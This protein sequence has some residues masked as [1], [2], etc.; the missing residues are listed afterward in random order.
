MRARSLVLRSVLA[1]AALAACTDVPIDDSRKDARLFPARGV[2][3][4]TVTYNGPRP[5][6]QGQHIVGNA[7]ILVFDRRNPP[8]PSG[9]AASA[10]NFVAVPGDV[11]FANEPRSIGAEIFCPPDPEPITASAPFAIAPL[12]GASYMIQAFYDRRGRFSPTFKFRNLPEAGD[13]GGGYIDLADF[14]K[15]GTNPAYQP[16]YLPVDVGIRQQADVP[17]GQ[18]PDFAIG[19]SGYVADNVPVTLGSIVP[20]TRPYFHPEGAEDL[21]PPQTSDANVTGDPLAVPVVAMTQDIHVFAPPASPTPQT[22]AAYES[23][24]KSIK[25]LWSV[26]QSEEATATDPAQPFGLQLPPLPP[27]GKGGLLVFSR[28]GS[29]PDN[30]AVPALWPEIAFLK[31][32]DDPFRTKTTGRPPAPLDPQ[33]LVVQG[34]PE[35]TVVT[36]EAVRPIVVLQA[37]TL[38]DGLVKTIATAPQQTP[39]TAALRDHVTALIRP[40]VLCFDP[41]RVDLGAVLVTPYAT[42]PSAD[43][44]ETGD[45][46]LFDPAVGKQPGVREVKLGCLPK[47]R[48]A[49]NAVYPTGQAWTVPNEMGTCARTEGAPGGTGPFVCSAKSRPVLLSQGARAVLEIVQAQDQAF[50]DAHPVPDAC[51]HQ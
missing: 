27:S 6:S 44:G 8:P 41:R 12:D 25:L 46:P 10:V 3:R 34:T 14:Q 48:F 51:L 18:I 35:E 23:S 20:F 9:V 7:I 33:S 5:C 26:S 4:G 22:L 24:F 43:K 17:E 40:A 21:P 28:G 1:L 50:C 42:G 30:P 29:I 37:I 49:I 16:K 38:D 19:Q 31:L 36:G 13:I 15:N 2:I 39:T 32:A 11:L 45:K 47:G